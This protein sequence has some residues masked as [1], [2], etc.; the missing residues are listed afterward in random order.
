MFSFAVE[1][2]PGTYLDIKQKVV[3]VAFSCDELT[4]AV[5]FEQSGHI[6]VVLF[7]VPSLVSQVCIQTFICL[8][9]IFYIWPYLF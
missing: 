9:S 2:S 5:C 1:Q 8:P 7:D 3:S 6:G 4:L